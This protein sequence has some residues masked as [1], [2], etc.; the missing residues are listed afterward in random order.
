MRKILIVVSLSE[1]G[2]L[3]QG[4][5]EQLSGSV[6]RLLEGFFC[7]VPTDP[8]DVL[9]AEHLVICPC[10][11][12]ASVYGALPPHQ[13]NLE[14]AGSGYALQ[15]GETLCFAELFSWKDPA[16]EFLHFMHVGKSDFWHV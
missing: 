9:G 7:G 10:L 4:G 15:V 14:G 8:G 1:S 3:V 6:E 5:L 2:N 12:E 11:P 16:Q 13:E